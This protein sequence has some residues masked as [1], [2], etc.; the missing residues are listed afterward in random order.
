MPGARGH[1]RG[2]GTEARFGEAETAQLFAA[3]ERR[4]P[5]IFLIFGTESVDRIHDERRLHAYKAAQ[6]GVAALQLLH[7]EAVLHIGHA[8]AA[9]ALKASAVKAQLAHRRN[10]LARET[11]LAKA[12]FDDGNHVCVDKLAGGAADEQFLFREARVEMEKIETL[13]FEG[14]G[15]TFRPAGSPGQMRVTVRGLL[16]N[17]VGIGTQP[18]GMGFSW[19][20]IQLMPNLSRNWPKRCAKKVSP[21]FMKTSPPSVRA[22]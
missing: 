8:G 5:G 13:K 10:Q 14:H 11:P 4:Q 6:A 7:D 22:L 19:I 20:T 18:R 16:F 12:L 1:A 3:G 21:I 2:I 15:C 17:V 9:V